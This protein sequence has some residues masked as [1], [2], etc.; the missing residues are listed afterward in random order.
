MQDAARKAI[1]F[2]TGK[3]RASLEVDDMLVYALVRALEIVGEAASKVSQTF[4][5][6]NPQIP[7]RASIG[8]RNQVIHAYSQVDLDIVW[9]TVTYNPPKLLIELDKLLPP[10]TE[11]GDA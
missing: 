10:D 11:S 4:R 5:D 9:D 1:A 2:A 3:T 7:W 6:Q 8:M